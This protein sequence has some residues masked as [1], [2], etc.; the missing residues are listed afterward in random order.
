MTIN[1]GE[2][3]EQR[4]ELE[5]LLTT[6]QVADLMQVSERH[7][8]NMVNRDQIPQPVRL[9]KTVRFRRAEIRR[10]LNGDADDGLRN[11]AV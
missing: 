11:Q 3:Q 9:G 7:I 10:F 5:S 6:K 2:V 1:K 4:D 8:Q